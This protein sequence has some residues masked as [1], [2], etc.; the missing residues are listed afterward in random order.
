MGRS[1]SYVRILKIQKNPV[2][3]SPII[4]S[5]PKVFI[6]EFLCNTEFFYGTDKTDYFLIT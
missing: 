3:D 1:I 6:T 2:I 4:K 5:G